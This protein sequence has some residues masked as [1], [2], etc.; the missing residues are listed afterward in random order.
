M[1]DRSRFGRIYVLERIH[2]KIVF[3]AQVGGKQPVEYTTKV[4]HLE[5]MTETFSAI[6]LK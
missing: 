3:K 6:S 5:K 4:R 2:N 1:I